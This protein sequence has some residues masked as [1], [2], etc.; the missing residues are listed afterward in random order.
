MMMTNAQSQEK[1]ELQFLVLPKQIK[2]QP[3]ELLVGEGKT[4]EV[5][6][7]GNELSATYKV[8]RLSSIVVGETTQ[9]D[10]GEPVFEVYGKANSIGASKQIILLIRKGKDNS[11]G[12]V[13][14][15]LDGELANFRGG[16]FLFINASKLNIAGVIGDK[17]FGLKPGKRQLLKPEP[18]HENGICQVTLAYQK[19]EKWKRFYDT[20]WPANKKYRSLIFFHQDPATGRLGIAPIIDMLTN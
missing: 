1:I 11:D 10:E 19:K 13:V 3:V 20:R 2:P 14:L 5:E 16:S 8:P 17:K 18:N 7:P 15:P 12:F 6:T 4:I 9:N